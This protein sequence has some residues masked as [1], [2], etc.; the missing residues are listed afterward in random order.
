MI[1]LEYFMLFS[2]FSVLV[3]TPQFTNAQGLTFLV[4]TCPCIN[5]CVFLVLV[6]TPQFCNFWNCFTVL[7]HRVS[8]YVIGIL[9]HITINLIMLHFSYFC[10]QIVLLLRLVPLLP[11]NM[12]NY[13]LSVTPVGI[14]EYMLAS[15]LGMMVCFTF[16]SLLS[17]FQSS[18]CNTVGLGCRQT[19]WPVDLMKPHIVTVSS[20]ILWP[21]IHHQLCVI[22]CFVLCYMSRHNYFQKFVFD[23][24][25]P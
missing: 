6:L 20:L 21:C 9:L 18:S 22:C 19:G 16:F 2:G 23:S 3:L 17:N 8:I 13:L 1:L 11:F 15:W 4:L 7:T 14:V 10:S 5:K 25:V 12:L 24:T